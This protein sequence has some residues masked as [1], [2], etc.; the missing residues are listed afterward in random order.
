MK[1]FF[2]LILFGGIIGVANIIPGVSG[3]TMAVVLGIY[4]KLI[5]AMSRFFSDVKGN[6]RF[7]AGIGIGALFGIALLSKLIKF[8]ITN[9]TMPT[10]F[11]FT[12]LILGSIPMLYGKARS[13]G[14]AGVKHYVVFALFIGLMAVLAFCTGEGGVQ[15]NMELTTATCLFL[16]VTSFIAAVGMLLPGVSGSM[17]LL[18]FG[19]YYTVTTAIDARDIFT[20]MPVAVG[21]GLGLLAG[22]KIIDFCLTRLPVVT[23]YAILGMVI[24]SLFAVVKNAFATAPSVSS[25][26]VSVVVFVIGVVISLAFEKWD[27]K[28]NPK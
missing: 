20:L 4:D 13:M 5:G 1:E 11:F 7:L 16:G 10:N 6:V 28:V 19:A 21:A 18:L 23:Y 8:C 26:V 9:Y 24:G 22:S 25:I 12:G 2:L 15:T 17:L 27:Q 14:R 3:G